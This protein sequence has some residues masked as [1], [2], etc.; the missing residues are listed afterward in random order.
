MTVIADVYELPLYDVL[1]CG[2]CGHELEQ[3]EYGDMPY[4]CPECG[5]VLSYDGFT[6]IKI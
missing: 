1:F 2:R 3:D 6:N 5:A 4:S